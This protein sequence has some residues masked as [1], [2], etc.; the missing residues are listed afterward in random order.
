[1]FTQAASREAFVARLDAIKTGIEHGQYADNT[2][3]LHTKFGALFCLRRIITFFTGKDLFAPFRAN[4]V[5]NA[6]VE[7]TKANKKLL[8]QATIDTTVKGLLDTL[9]N[10]VRRIEQKTAIIDS[11]A[12]LDVLLTQADPQSSEVDGETDEEEQPKAPSNKRSASAKPVVDAAA[13]V[14]STIAAPKE[15]ASTGIE[16]SKHLS[17]QVQKASHTMAYSLT[18]DLAKEPG[19][20]SVSPIGV[21]HM[22]ACVVAMCDE[23]SD[24]D[25]KKRFA[26]TDEAI[27]EFAGATSAAK[28]ANASVSVAYASKEQVVDDEDRK[29]LTNRFVQVI[30]PK[31]DV[32]TRRLVNAWQ[33]A[34]GRTTEML[35]K[36]YSKGWNDRLASA[37][38]SFVKLTPEIGVA[39]DSEIADNHFT[40]LDGAKAQVHFW[41][42]SKLKAVEVDDFTMCVVPYTSQEGKP[43]QKVVLMPNEGADQNAFR[44]KLTVDYLKKSLEAHKTQ[45][46]IAKTVYLPR[47][48]VEHDE[49]ALPITLPKDAISLGHKVSS[50][51]QSVILQEKVL[52]LGQHVDAPNQHLFNRPFFYFVMDGDNVL[53]EGRVDDVAA[54]AAR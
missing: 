12:K 47:M 22:L 37:F 7:Y 4:N 52:P 32:S 2:L 40:L 39:P 21:M 54:L 29:Y 35:D 53:I 28:E 41:G 20:Y 19:S 27:D 18:R 33:Q 14:A 43:L 23:A 9:S 13:L 48:S 36:T 11:K 30:H 10:K 3:G 49:I 50:L 24:A 26:L 31:D 16:L 15:P 6:V 1:M 8:D 46:G 34:A 17:E 51:M 38:I 5:A 42:Y 25:L 45:D 44:K